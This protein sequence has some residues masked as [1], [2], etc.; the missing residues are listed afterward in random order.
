MLKR[1]RHG[2]QV[3]LACG[4][5]PARH[6]VG[7]IGLLLGVFRAVGADLER[8]IPASGARRQR[9][10]QRGERKR[11]NEVLAGKVDQLPDAFPA[12]KA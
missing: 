8:E 4:M 5:D 10:R 6:L 12:A 2:R 9:Q 11:A 1:E 3:G 7:G